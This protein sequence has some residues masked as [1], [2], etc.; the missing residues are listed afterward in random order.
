MCLQLGSPKMKDEAKVSQVLTNF[1]EYLTAVS[2]FSD[3]DIYMVKNIRR[4]AVQG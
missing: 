4:P 1:Y 2:P 3:F